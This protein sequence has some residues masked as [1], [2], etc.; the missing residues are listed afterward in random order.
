MKLKFSHYLTVGILFISL[1]VMAQED[2]IPAVNNE[3]TEL[4]EHPEL[5]L[6]DDKTLIMDLDSKT[7]KT[8][9][10][11]G[12]ANQKSK[13]YVPCLTPVAQSATLLK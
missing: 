13:P 9:H 8:I 10:T 4:N 2:V 3:A 6:N 1:G 12:A 5:N 7:S 11:P